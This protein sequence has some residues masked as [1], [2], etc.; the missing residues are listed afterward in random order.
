MNEGDLNLQ[1]QA[2]VTKS[3]PVYVIMSLIDS[4]MDQMKTE[5]HEFKKIV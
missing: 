2:K 5:S 3:F 1:D 4:V